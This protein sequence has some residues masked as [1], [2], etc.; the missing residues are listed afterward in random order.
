MGIRKLISGLAIAAVAVGFAG[1][2]AGASTQTKATNTGSGTRTADL[3]LVHGIPGD[4]DFPVDI[5]VY[6]LVGDNKRFEGVTF[7][8]VAPLEDLKPGIYWV[9]IRPAGAPRF[10]KPVLSHW[11]GLFAGQS[12]SV[13]AHLTEDGQPKLSI[14]KNDLSDPGDGNARVTVRHLAEA[15][16]VDIQVNGDVFVP[17]LTNP[18]EAKAEV[19]AGTYAVGVAPA[20]D[21][22]PV[23]GPVDLDFAESTN[24]I[25]YA[26]GS[27]GGGS[28]TPLVQVLP[29]K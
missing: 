29:T 12:K 4:N 5:S 19:P 25:V 11:F 15:P 28:F 10:S 21:P 9:G 26:V 23:F 1:S 6:R 16:A 18:N 27:L 14:L 3:T 2:A 22:T 7:G 24:T 13:V 20:G 17:G 8:T